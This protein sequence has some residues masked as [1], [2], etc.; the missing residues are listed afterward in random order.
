MMGRESATKRKSMEAVRR[1]KELG[2]K[3]QE[4]LEVQNEM[5]G[6]VDEDVTRVEGKVAVAN[7]R[8]G[9]IS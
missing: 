1:Q 9:R 6:L 5:L 4:E 8:V 7:K 3:I 2:V